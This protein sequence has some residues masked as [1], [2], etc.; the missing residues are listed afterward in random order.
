MNRLRKLLGT[1]ILLGANG[2]L[3][4][5]T[6]QQAH[7]YGGM[8][9]GQEWNNFYAVDSWRALCTISIMMALMA[10]PLLSSVYRK[11][12]DVFFGIN[13]PETGAVALDTVDVHKEP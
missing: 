8:S 12:F 4:Q 5:N 6:I 2:V 13:A 3:V 1:I 9:F 11:R 10:I 7:R